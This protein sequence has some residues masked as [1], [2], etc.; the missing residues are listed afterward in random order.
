MISR[1]FWA[2]LLALAMGSTSL[3]Q[4]VPKSVTLP[5]APAP[6]QIERDFDAVFH[7]QV[8]YPTIRVC[9]K[10]RPQ[11]GTGVVVRSAKQEVEDPSKKDD[12]KVVT[13]VYVNTMLTCAHCVI[14]GQDYTADI[15]T[16]EA[17]GTT[18]KDWERNN[19]LVYHYAYDLDLAVCIFITSH[20]VDVAEMDFNTRLCIGNN[21]LH[22]GCGSGED[23]RFDTGQITGLKGKVRP[24]P[25]DV[26]R[27]NMMTIFGDSGGPAFYKNKVIGL[28]Q[29][30]KITRFQGEPF[31][32]PGISFCMPIG[33]VKVL[34]KRENNT[35]SFVYNF[36]SEVP[37]LPIVQLKYQP[38]NWDEIVL[39]GE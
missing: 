13:T 7:K 30:I 39:E 20:P 35:L 31:P 18:F 1:I 11:F 24:H 17:D 14:P 33:V 26:Y 15:A 37:K 16:Y 22:V 3:S 34:D 27:T 10:N 9:N 19:L 6:R 25:T 23:P 38:I 36:N 28:M 8:L 32:V 5:K 2:C 29:A 4:V 21:V 12:K